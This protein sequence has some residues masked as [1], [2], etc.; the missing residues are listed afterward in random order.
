MAVLYQPQSSKNEAQVKLSLAV[1]CA[2]GELLVRLSVV[3]YVVRDGEARQ[4][5]GSEAELLGYIGKKAGGFIRRPVR[6]VK[7]RNIIHSTK[8]GIPTPK[9]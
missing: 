1:M 8:A 4:Q 6:C 7:E 5:A 2:V 9:G 3:L